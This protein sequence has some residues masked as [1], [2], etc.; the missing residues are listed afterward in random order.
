MFQLPTSNLKSKLDSIRTETESELQ[1]EN[2][3]K[4]KQ[5]KIF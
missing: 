5:H 3:I 1:L 2:K 4:E